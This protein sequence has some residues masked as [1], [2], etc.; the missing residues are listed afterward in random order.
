MTIQNVFPEP[1]DKVIPLKEALE[2]LEYDPEEIKEKLEET[3]LIYFVL[4]PMELEE[5][6]H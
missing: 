2:G 5:K 4:T 6:K 1:S 3:L